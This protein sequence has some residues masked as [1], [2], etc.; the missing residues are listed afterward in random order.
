METVFNCATGETSQVEGPPLGP[1]LPPA[2]V[3]MW[4]VRVVLAEDGILGDVDAA[5]STLPA[6][7]Q[8]RWR[9][10]PNFVRSSPLVLSMIEE[11]GSTL[12]LTAEAVDDIVTRAAALAE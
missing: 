12:G 6:T 1:A 5:V 3:A 10:A 4:R 8:E 9:G 11:L 7:I 2:E